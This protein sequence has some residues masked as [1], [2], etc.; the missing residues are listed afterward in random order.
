MGVLRIHFTGTDLARTQIAA[1]PD[2]LWE[3]ML[4]LHWLQGSYWR[5]MP[6]GRLVFGSWRAGVVERLRRSGS[7]AEVRDRLLP[8]SPAQSDFPDFLTPPEGL[9]GLDAG[10]EA[11]LAAPRQQLRRELVPLAGSP[12]DRHW[13]RTLAGG[14]P[15][16][17][18]QLERLL[19]GY[20]AHAIAPYWPEVRRRV[21]AEHA[22]RLQDIATGGVEG[23]LARLA[24]GMRWCRPVLEVYHP[25][26]RDLHLNGRGLTLIPSYFCWTAIPL[27]DPALPPVLVYAVEHQASPAP[28]AL[29]AAA[30]TG[31]GTLLGST[32]AAIL[33]LVE[34]GCTVSE[35][36]TRT[37]VSVASASRHAQILREAG[38]VTSHRHTN[39]VTH[40]LT[41]LGSALLRGEL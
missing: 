7:G 16:H 28:A 31:L 12:N 21:E 30:R 26:T 35:L 34:G 10:L 4:S 41:P 20:H 33:E 2:P 27:A 25:T 14:G 15:D 36:A 1:V 11:A 6:A 5:M 37:G 24:P 9:L 19:R 13:P 29:P 40:L 22:R 18:R 17:L 39:T 8:L 3:I 23:M 32:R 38:L